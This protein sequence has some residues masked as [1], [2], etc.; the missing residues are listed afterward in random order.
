MAEAD[1]CACSVRGE[2]VILRQAGEVI[3]Q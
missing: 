3:R 2:L 1:F